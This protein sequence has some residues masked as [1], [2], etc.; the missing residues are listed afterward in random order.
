[1]GRDSAASPLFL[2]QGVLWPSW[3]PIVTPFLSVDLSSPVLF[4][5]HC[6][7]VRNTGLEIIALERVWPSPLCW[8]GTEEIP[9]FAKISSLTGE[10]TAFHLAKAWRQNLSEVLGEPVATQGN[11]ILVP[12]SFTLFIVLKSEWWFYQLEEGEVRKKNSSVRGPGLRGSDDLY[13]HQA[14][15]VPWWLKFVERG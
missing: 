15:R 3:S 1:M 2:K 14:L 8:W 5:W 4:L 9:E 10:E 11:S 12:F 7:D 13:F 6:L